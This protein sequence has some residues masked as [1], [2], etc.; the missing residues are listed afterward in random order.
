M[1]EAVNS[2]LKLLPIGDGTNG[3]PKGAVKWSSPLSWAS[4]Y[5]PSPDT[6]VYQ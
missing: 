2:C 6:S 4:L 3:V 1:A 5:G